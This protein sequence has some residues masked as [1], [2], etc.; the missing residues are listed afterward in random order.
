MSGK[1]VC[2][3]SND[4]R[5]GVPGSLFLIETREGGSAHA[6]FLITM[7]VKRIYLKFNNKL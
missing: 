7:M 6:I 4:L 2:V 3:S 5:W 1:F